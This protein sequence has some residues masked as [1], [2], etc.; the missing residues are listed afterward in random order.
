MTSAPSPTLF[1]ADWPSSAALYLRDGAV[2]QPGRLFR[3]PTLAATSIADGG[4]G[5]GRR[6][7]R[8]SSSAPPPI[9]T[10]SSPRRS[11]ASAGER[12]CSTSPGAA[13]AAC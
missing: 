6:T 4:R 7:A 11:T 12:A 5:R 3:N 9:I 10:A 13:I 8:R 2:P 1:R